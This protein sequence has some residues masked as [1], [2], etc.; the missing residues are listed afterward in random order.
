MDM[1]ALMAVVEG[2]FDDENAYEYG[3]AK[4]AAEYASHVWYH[5][6]EEDFD[7]FVDT[8][9]YQGMWFAENPR[10]TG[11]YGPNQY[12]VRLNFKNPLIVTEAEYAA[13]KPN[14][15]TSWA[16]KAQAEGH[17]AVIIQ[18]IIDGD[19]ESTVCGV[20]DPSIIEILD[21]DIYQDEIE[22][23]RLPLRK[24]M[25]RGARGNYGALVAVM[26]PS[27]FIRLTTPA[28]EVHQIYKDKF[29]LSIAD[30]ESGADETFNKNQYNMPFLM[31]NHETG[32]VKGHE[33][34][35][36]AAMVAK[37]GGKKFPCYLIFKHSYEYEVSYTKEPKWEETDGE[38]LTQTFKT[39]GE[40]E[41]FVAELK[42]LNDDADHDYWYSNFNTETYGGGTMKGSPRSEK[43][44]YDAWLLDDMP[45]QLIGQY[46]ELV[47]VPKSRMRIGLVKGY[48]HFK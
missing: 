18:D 9:R 27:D 34:R 6:S 16:K 20:I 24:D 7:A 31:V 25:I 1:R 5:G 8:G 15:P 36:R 23:A 26:D 14:G 48:S 10:L 22:E 33:G 37:E 21:K 4:S 17:D 11:Y 39:T 44:D 41:Q 43:W 46:D 29:A 28:D 2:R 3:A 30:Y 45:E 42:R 13:H 40:L 35:H 47:V 12:K 19:T 32:K 38:A